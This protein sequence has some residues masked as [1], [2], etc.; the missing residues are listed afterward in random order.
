M[1]F[2]VYEWFNTKTN[3]IIYV[4]KGCR[5]RYKV[6]KHNRLFNLE[7][8]KDEYDSRIIKYFDSEAEAFDYEYQRVN[9]LKQIGQCKCNIYN[10]GLG[11]TTSWWTD[12]RRKWYSE[13]NVMKSQ[14]NRKRMSIYNPMKNP[15]IVKKV[16]SKTC[17]KV[18]L[19]N[20]I[21]NSL[22]QLADE[23]GICVTSI[24][25]WIER[26]YGRNQEPCYYYGQEPKPFIIKTRE[27]NNK[28]VIIDGKYFKN[29]KTGAEYLGVWSEN[30]IR[31]IK[32]NRLCK[33]HKCEYANQ[34]PSTN[35]ND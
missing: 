10:G 1:E 7:I 2:Y 20:K 32:S 28:P 12:K 16:K 13:N 18:V 26:G 17:K 3:E 15:E 6:R 9:E 8:Q 14:E 35:L 24:Q 27:T 5:N 11:G 33:G 30:L 22:K 4:G 23:F 34:Q 19:G 21:Y 29:V 25:Y 31:A